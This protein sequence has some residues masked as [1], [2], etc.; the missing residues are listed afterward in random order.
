MEFKRGQESQL[1][2]TSHRVWLKIKGQR[3]LTIIYS[4]ISVIRFIGLHACM[5][6][7]QNV[8]EPD[9][10]SKTWYPKN[11]GFA[12]LYAESLAAVIVL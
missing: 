3:K 11:Q 4:Q 7:H 12:Q 10:Q 6:V 1:K 5:H 9:R 2:A 8:T